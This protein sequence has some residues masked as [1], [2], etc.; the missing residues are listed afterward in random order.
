MTCTA[1]GLR[2]G[3]AKARTALFP[4]LPG[5]WLTQNDIREKVSVLWA[6]ES[7]QH[8]VLYRGRAIH[9]DA[10]TYSPFPSPLPGPLPWAQYS[11]YLYSMLAEPTSVFVHQCMVIFSPVV[12]LVSH[13]RLYLLTHC[14][15]GPTSLSTFKKHCL[16]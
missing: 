7:C 8:L 1:E 5:G 2:Y 12:P 3:Q 15:D 11:G 9:H 10:A 16:V 6:C 14:H 13:R 4:L